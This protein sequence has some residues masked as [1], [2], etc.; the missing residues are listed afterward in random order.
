MGKMRRPF[1][2]LFAMAFGLVVLGCSDTG[3]ESPWIGKS[4]PEYRFKP[5]TPGGDITADAFKGKVVLLDFWATWCGPCIEIMPGISEL[6][7]KHKDAGLVVLGVSS[8]TPTTVEK[9]RD[10]RFDP[11]YDLVIDAGAKVNQVYGVNSLPTTVLIGRDGKVR[12]Y[13]VGADPDHGMAKLEEA[14]VKAL[15]EKA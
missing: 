2:L 5:I 6:S 14:V 12:L 9:F 15:A 11:G 7:K 8:E 1:A 10:N 3:P 4:A 13:E